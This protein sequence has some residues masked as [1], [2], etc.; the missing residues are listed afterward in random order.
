MIGSQPDLSTAHWRKSTHSNGD[1]GDCVEVAA[2]ASGGIV[3]VRDTKTAPTGAV[4]TFP[5][6]QWTHF[7]TAVHNGQFGD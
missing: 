7:I 2:N 6:S 3:P 4:L 1:G 5:A